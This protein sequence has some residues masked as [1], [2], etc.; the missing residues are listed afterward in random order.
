MLGAS[1]WDH[2]T[3]IGGGLILLAALLSII[4]SNT[5]SH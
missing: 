5:N 2:R 4:K 3:L 1:N